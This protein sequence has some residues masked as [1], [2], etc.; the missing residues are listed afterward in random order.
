MLAISAEQDELHHPGRGT[1]AETPAIRAPSSSRSQRLFE[2]Y[3][4]CS[5]ALGGLETPA[6]ESTPSCASSDVRP[7][8]A[9]GWFDV[10]PHRLD[11]PGART[12]T[13]VGATPDEAHRLARLPGRAGIC[14]RTNGLPPRCGSVIMRRRPE[15]RGMQPCG[16]GRESLDSTANAFG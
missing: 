12:Q 3:L 13:C 4:L 10:Q 5:A 6:A 14:K 2:A 1:G 15:T 7:C 11:H 9:V 8:H 16:P